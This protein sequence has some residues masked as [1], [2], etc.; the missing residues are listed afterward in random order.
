MNRNYSG[1]GSKEVWGPEALKTDEV[2]DS[3]KIY[4]EII[5]KMATFKRNKYL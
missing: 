4:L 5:Q 1:A 2:Q 3:V